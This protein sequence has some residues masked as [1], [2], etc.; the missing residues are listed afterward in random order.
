M[1]G[2][3][4]AGDFSTCNFSSDKLD[5]PTGLN[6]LGAVFFLLF[7]GMVLAGNTDWMKMQ[8]ARL[9]ERLTYVNHIS[10]IICFTSFFFHFLHVLGAL[11]SCDH[12]SLN[13]LTYCEYLF[14]CPWMM[15][16]FCI[17]GGPDVKEN[18]KFRALALT[19]L[20]LLFGFCATILEAMMLRAVCFGFGCILFV[21]LVKV[22]NKCIQEHSDHTEGLFS[23]HAVTKSP[24]LKLGR[25]IF[26][27]WCLFPTWW[28]LGADGLALYSPSD[29]T[30][31]M[32]KFLLN[33][34][35]KGLYI[36]MLWKLKQDCVGYESLMEMSGGSAVIGAHGR[37]KDNDGL[38]MKQPSEPSSAKWHTSEPHSAKWSQHSWHTVSEMGCVIPQEFSGPEVGGQILSDPAQPF[39]RAYSVQSTQSMKGVCQEKFTDEMLMPSAG[40]NM[41][42]VCHED[43]Y[44]ARTTIPRG[45]SQQD[46]LPGFPSRTASKDSTLSQESL[47]PGIVSS[48]E[49]SK[50]RRASKEPLVNSLEEPASAEMPIRKIISMSSKGS[51]KEAAAAGISPEVLG[52]INTIQQLDPSVL[53]ALTTINDIGK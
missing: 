45:S 13:H 14:T 37:H 6:C 35:A 25:K 21:G 46:L 44:S 22:L 24:Y 49:C 50:E 48:R 15:V 8:R 28:L 3:H 39:S 53:K 19:V 33:I 10:A 38:P 7:M 16:S 18:H 34:V 36:F 2:G 32:I 23:S 17:V 51:S 29:D 31:S 42:A 1:A 9:E 26:A 40:L 12:K 27:T 30:N 41:P 20:L 4:G 47:S 5:T 11:A 43:S 52:A